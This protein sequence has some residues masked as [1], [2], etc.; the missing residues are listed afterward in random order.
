MQQRI[1][2]RDHVICL[3]DDEREPI[4]GGRKESMGSEAEGCWNPFLFLFFYQKEGTN[5]P[6]G[7]HHI[8]MSD[9]MFH[10]ACHSLSLLHKQRHVLESYCIQW[11]FTSSPFPF[12]SVYQRVGLKINN[13][14]SSLLLVDMIHFSLLHIAVNL[15]V[16]KHVY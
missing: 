4:W 14:S 5:F 9:N 2:H 11:S 15:T 12:P 3:K 16:L 1:T 7:N 6:K 13:N 8:H 10:G